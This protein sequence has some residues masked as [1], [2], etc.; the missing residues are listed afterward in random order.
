MWVSVK[1][2]EETQEK[3]GKAIRVD[4]VETTESVEDAMEECVTEECAT[5]EQGEIAEEFEVE[6]ADIKPPVQPINNNM[7]QTDDQSENY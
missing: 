7:C 5:D 3:N 4:T 6:A 1:E 2:K